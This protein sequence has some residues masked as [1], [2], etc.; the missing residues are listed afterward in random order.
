MLAFKNWYQSN[1]PSEI[2]RE[3][4]MQTI[5]MTLTPYY[6]SSSPFFFN[7]EGKKNVVTP[8]P[9]PTNTHTQCAR[10]LPHTNAGVCVGSL[11]VGC[12]C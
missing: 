8:D 2:K 5:F 9:P 7:K 12:E 11:F 6:L 3:S 4:G 1:P 10:H